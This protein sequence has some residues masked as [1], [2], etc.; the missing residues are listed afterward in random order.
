MR[1]TIETSPGEFLDKLSILEIK[2]ERITDPGKLANVRRELD[3]LRTTWEASS[4]A[5]RD[6]SAALVELKQVNV[7]L[8]EVEDRLREKEAQGAFDEE[9]VELARSVYKTNDRR[10][11][12]KRDLNLAMGSDLIEE[13]SYKAY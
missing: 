4:L 6:I 9:F 11:A 12:I 3:L 13:K 10:A 2:A 5:D 8:W 1:L 7:T